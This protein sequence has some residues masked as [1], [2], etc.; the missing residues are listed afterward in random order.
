MFVAIKHSP[1]TSISLDTI[2]VSNDGRSADTSQLYL[3]VAAGSTAT[4]VRWL[5]FDRGRCCKQRGTKRCI[6]SKQN[7]RDGS[8][9]EFTQMLLFFLFIFFYRMS[10]VMF[11]V[12]TIPFMLATSNGR[13]YK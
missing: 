11:S 7:G 2:I 4:S 13:V 10:R 12:L 5:P 1:T 6:K 8:V 3:P 9:F